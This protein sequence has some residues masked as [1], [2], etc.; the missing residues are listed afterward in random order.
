MFNPNDYGL[1]IEDLPTWM[2]PRYRG[3]DWTVI[4][5][6]ILCIV[7]C[8][9]ILNAPIYSI[10]RSIQAETQLY[11]IVETASVLESGQIYPRWAANF[12]YGYGS[13]IFNYIAPLPYYVGG[14][15]LI[16]TQDAPPVGLKAMSLFGVFFLGLATIAFA[17]RRWGDIVGMI[18]T[19]LVLFSPTLASTVHLYTDL[20]ILWAGAFFM[21]SL[22]GADRLTE[23]GR[24]R[25]M[26]LLSFMTTG[27][28]LSHYS[29]APILFA[30]LTGWV[31]IHRSSQFRWVVISL[32]FGMAGA[33]LFLIP[34]VFE[35]NAVQW[36]PLSVYPTAV[37]T[38]KLLE[39]PPQ[40]DITLF[41]PPPTI[42]LG[43]AQW[44]LGL[45]GAGWLL[46]K[47]KNADSYFV[48]WG[49]VFI[50]LLYYPESWAYQNSFEAIRPTDIMLPLTLCAAL[51][52]GQTINLI[53]EQVKTT[54]RRWVA[55]TIVTFIVTLSGANTIIAPEY[56]PISRADLTTQH[57]NNELRGYML[58]SITEGH[59]LPKGV[60]ELPDVSRFVV[61]NLEQIEKIDRLSLPR[62][63]RV[64]I[65][66]HAPSSDSFIIENRSTEHEIT[67]LTFNYP[68]W[69]AT[70]NQEPIDLRT[71]SPNGFI[72]LV[73][74]P[75]IN[76]IHLYFSE[77]PLR[78]L[79]WGISG[80][81]LLMMVALV[82]WRE[83]RASPLPP[84]TL[85][86]LA[87]RRQRERHHLIAL[88]TSA[89]A[90]TY[91][92]IHFYPELVTTQTPSTSIPSEA[93]PMERIIEG[94]LDFL[95]FNL[96]QTQVDRG[97]SVFLNTY[98]ASSV[99]NLPNYQ[100]EL[101]V[102]HN[103]EVVQHQTYRHLANWPSR[104]WHLDGYVIATYHIPM[105]TTPGDYTISLQVGTCGRLDLRPC[106]VL[107]PRDVYDLRGPTT[108]Q[109]ILPKTIR[110]E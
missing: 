82:I 47:R 3:I 59:L 65:L 90:V 46:S 77:N 85:T 14:V 56:L 53:E 36:Q 52:A 81:S 17:R 91:G 75:E 10:P 22:W 50:L 16:L 7:A 104:E 55:V 54:F 13:P 57:L 38:T 19:A 92:V 76:D 26:A 99:P 64:T 35:A 97:D 96:E 101:S 84:N 100:L 80:I 29:L 25:D 73:I 66:E 61:G 24:G 71:Q 18:A 110:V 48:G 68:G 108:Q 20:G 87:Y 43:I 2:R 93:V 42:R 69:K 44:L 37:D 1:E 105:P 95:G 28:L 11:R 106:D 70:R 86:P 12:N 6:L 32:L 23:H 4:A 89:L 74:E 62:N 109:I 60:E 103:G 49:L 63:T 51:V 21:G 67:I 41:N 33:A 102:L 39:V 78:Q 15:Y 83:R 45:V 40:L 94:G 27:L 8:W 72:G 31:I 5:T 30:M 9:S 98:W 58:G 34:A 79:A 88:V 107:E